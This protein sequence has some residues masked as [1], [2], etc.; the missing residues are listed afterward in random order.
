ME[1]QPHSV[2]DAAGL[3]AASIDGSP[4]Q[5]AGS[6]RRPLP[7][8]ASLEYQRAKLAEESQAAATEL[9]V[10]R[11]EALRALQTGEPNGG[12]SANGLQLEHEEENGREDTVVIVPGES[13]LVL[14]ICRV[15][16]GVELNSEPIGE[17]R[18]GEVVGKSLIILFVYPRL[19]VVS[20][21]AAE[22]LMLVH[23]CVGD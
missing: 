15:R 18:A 17:I 12:T 20:L 4:Q 8:V 5:Q 2:A 6:P 16:V 9:Q 1:P 23:S 7:A 13:Y 22:M 11:A 10:A 21:S 14:T 3:E 19:A